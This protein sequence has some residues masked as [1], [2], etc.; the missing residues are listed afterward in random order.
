MHAHCD[1]HC[2]TYCNTHCNTFG[3]PQ[4]VEGVSLTLD[5]IVGATGL[6]LK[7]D[8]GVPLVYAGFGALMVTTLVSYISHS[9]VRKGTRA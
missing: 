6:E 2:N 7:S 3:L 1:I 4:Q 9:Q 8:P 5:D